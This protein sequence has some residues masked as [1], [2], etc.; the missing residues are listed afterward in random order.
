[1]VFSI[2]QSDKSSSF[3]TQNNSVPSI[4]D[5]SN[6]EAGSEVY[7]SRQALPDNA[8]APAKK[9]QKIIADPKNQLRVDTSLEEKIQVLDKQLV[10]INAQLQAQGVNPLGAQEANKLASETSDTQKRL[11]ALKEH[12][13]NNTQ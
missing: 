3:N 10:D 13:E 1:M 2:W 8:P 7:S 4:H 6:I 5:S 12:I 9:L 11:Q